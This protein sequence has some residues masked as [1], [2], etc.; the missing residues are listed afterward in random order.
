[1][2]EVGVSDDA[3]GPVDVGQTGAVAANSR[4]NWPNIQ[5][6]YSNRGDDLQDLNLYKWIVKFWKNDKD[7][8]PQFFGYK[9]FPDWPLKEEYAKWQ[10]ALFKPWDQSFE[11]NKDADG[12][13]VSVLLEFMWTPDFPWHN[14]GD[15]IRVMRNQRSIDTE[16][17]Q[18]INDDVEFSPTEPR[19]N[20][21]NQ[22]AVE[23]NVSQEFH[24]GWV[25]DEDAAFADQEEEKL[26][27]MNKRIPH[28]HDWSVNWSASESTALVEYAA[29]LR[30]D[31]VDAGLND[32]EDV[33]ELFNE[34]LHRPENAQTEG[35][36]FLVYHHL[37]HHK[38]ILDYTE[39]QKNGTLG[40]NEK[41]PP[42][43][44]ILVN[45]SPGTGK[46]WV[47]NT[48]RNI[49]R[50]LH[51]TNGADMA[52]A[53]TGCS[54]S[55]INGATHYRVCNIPTGKE[56]KGAPTAFPVNN[57]RKLQSTRNV[58]SKVVTRLID[59][60]SMMSRSM[61]TW[62]CHRSK[63]L[64]K[65]RI[66]VNDD[67]TVIGVSRD[68][69]LPNDVLE[70]SFGGMGIV[71]LFG[72]INQLPPVKE[73]VFYD[74]ARGDATKSDGQGFVK[75]N[76]F[77]QQNPT[78]EEAEEE[79]ST[80]VLLDEVL[81]QNE[82]PFKTCVTHMSTGDMTDDDVDF[83]LSRVMEDL[84]AEEKVQFQRDAIHLVPRWKLANEIVYNYINDH[85]SEK[86]V[87]LIKAQYQTGRDNGV[88]CMLKECGFK[89]TEVL[90]I[91][92]KVM[93]LHNFCVEHK[94][95]NGSI[96]TVID[97]RFRSKEGPSDD[98]GGAYCIVDIPL[99]T[100]PAN[101][102]LIP[103]MSSKWVPIPVVTNRCERKC[104]SI[105]TFP[106]RVSAALSIHK[107]QGMTI[108]DG[109]LFKK[110]V[111]WFPGIRDRL[112]AGLMLVA[113]SRA[114]DSMDFAVGNPKSE[115]NRAN[116]KNTGKGKPYK[117]RRDFLNKLESLSPQSMDRTIKRITAIDPNTDNQTYEGGCEF[118][119][120]WFRARVSVVSSN[121]E[122][123]SNVRNNTIRM[124]GG[125]IGEL[126]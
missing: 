16:V 98:N 34:G 90:C 36:K 126:V 109:Q 75:F 87:A 50:L 46:S 89:G 122:G 57:A 53:P 12:K 24:R 45:G 15:I 56:F 88:N 17:G 69:N 7:T 110:V 4:F 102:A 79:E 44:M 40:N 25:D 38:L 42:S 83:I 11:E 33:V 124:P 21:T 121:N 113:S 2:D 9:H 30:S 37:Y 1:M 65:P 78:P 39:K 62:L 43:Q 97:I 100:I 99:S 111:I 117:H 64:R 61:L 73:K 41:Y 101:E 77:I 103:G 92:A 20:E 5:K 82:G 51:G 123:I 66:V 70:R 28:G 59:E 19:E 6:R 35:Q 32:A 93:I 31:E 74:D 27:T 67:N 118:L 18:M 22:Q 85:P 105:T 29:R 108:G 95:M 72:D 116:L 114:K 55:I 120:R 76:R 86:P 13:Y 48:L 125:V 94:I 52:S 47:I 71:G 3:G 96:G 68:S 112:T 84:P 115:L 10:L 54:A 63:E 8:I 80:I 106:I 107:A 26:Q 49:T 81:R 14:R 119:L 23:A 104:C 58:M 60:H 91:G